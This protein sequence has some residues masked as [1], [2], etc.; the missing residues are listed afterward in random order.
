[1]KNMDE[2]QS[3][4][5]RIDLAKLI[6]YISKDPESELV[7]QDT[8]EL[9][10]LIVNQHTMT[11][12]EVMNWFEVSRQRL[13]GL[14]NQGYL[15]ELKGG[16][17]SRSNVE[18]M[19]WQQIE[20]GRLRY[21]LYPVFRLLD[22]CL[23]I[24]KR[25]FF[26]CQTMVKVESKGEHYNP[27]NHPYKLALEEMLS[28]AVETYKKNQTVVYLMQKGFDE[29]YN[30]DDLQRVEKEGMWFAGEHTKDD[31]LEMLERTSK[32]ETGLEKA[33]NFQVTINELASM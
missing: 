29:V 22:C 15:N 23:I 3:V 26:D 11:T 28:A 25:R 10:K 1:M 33:D 20:G 17:Y 7:V 14:K 24:D 19:R 27:V 6:E 32:T 2:K 9:L 21:E 16:L 30:L 18:T 31:F 4:N 8:E 5:K 13:L 12:G